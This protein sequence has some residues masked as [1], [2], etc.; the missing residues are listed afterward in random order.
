MFNSIKK[1][2]LNAKKQFEKVNMR[3][4]SMRAES[5]PTIRLN[6]SRYVFR[7]ILPADSD[8]LFQMHERL[9]KETIYFRYMAPYRPTMA[10][11]KTVCGLKASAGAAFVAQH[12][13]KDDT[14]V[15]LAYYRFDPNHPDENPEFAIVV[16]D[17]FQGRGI[18]KALLQQLCRHAATAGVRQLNA[19]ILSRNRRMRNLLYRADY[20]FDERIQYDT[21]EATVD[22]Q[23][24]TSFSSNGF[25]DHRRLADH[26]AGLYF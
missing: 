17:R 14:I 22:L 23:P 26:F 4:N 9:S 12:K 11:M 25:F 13:D 5:H 3:I 6:G 20:P 7:Q 18:G 16:E 19:S 2:V 24:D 8:K 1:Y 10:E 21:V 15:G